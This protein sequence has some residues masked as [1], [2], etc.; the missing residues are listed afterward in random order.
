M[1]KSCYGSLNK[2]QKDC[3]ANH[4]R[5]RS[6]MDIG[7]ANL[8]ISK[9]L[10][11]LGA[12]NVLAVD[13]SDFRYYIYKLY[14][15]DKSF[16]DKIRKDYPK[17]FSQLKNIQYLK[18]YIHELTERREVAMVSWPVNW[19]IGLP[20]VLRDTRVVIYLGKNTD[21][22]VCGSMDMWELLSRREILDYVPDKNNSLIV[23]GPN[24]VNRK[25]VGEESAAM[26]GEVV[27]YEYSERL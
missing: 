20:V 1:M 10:I 8:E 25:M 9:E 21:G 17:L 3:V 27:S 24:K 2:I 16:H 12:N 23:Y 13:K 6:V 19:P 4:V 26:L 18:S 15:S 14:Y 11:S 5:N 7:A 22:T